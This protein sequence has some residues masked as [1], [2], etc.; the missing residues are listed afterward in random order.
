MDLQ[1]FERIEAS[2]RQF[3][4]HF[5]PAFARKQWRERSRDYLRGLLVQSAERSNAENLA[6]AVPGASPRVLQR[7]LTEARWDDDAVTRR[8]QQDLALRLT[9][10]DAVW[11]VDESGFPKQGKKSVG[12]A[13]QY[14]GALGKM[15]NCQVGVFLAY[16]S[17]R[18]RAL[19]DKRLFLPKEWTDDPD[20]CAAAGVPEAQRSYRTKTEIALALL[21]RAQRWGHLQAGWVTGDDAYGVVPEFRDALAQAGLRYVLE[22]PSHLT[23]WPLQPTWEQPV[24]G[25]FGRPP[26]ARPVAAQRQTVRERAVVLPQEAWQEITVAVGAQGP[27]TYRFACERVRVTRRRKPG[28]ELWLIQKQNLDGTEPRAF[29]SNAPGDT[30]VET[31]AR[32]AMS[33]WPIETEFEDEKSQVALDEYEVRGWAGW[34]HHVTMCLLASAFLLRLPQEWGEKD[35]PDHAAA[36]LPDRLRTVAAPALDERG[37]AGVAGGDPASQRTGETLARQTPSPTKGS[38]QVGPGSWQLR[39]TSSSQVPSLGC[40]DSSL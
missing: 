18:G 4:A 13:R 25:G 2:F 5:A 16:V 8:L 37:V 29:F 36:G 15:A 31:L 7:F 9:H 19:V 27:R 1:D 40:V 3:H 39:A 34:H 6:E 21:Q 23:V 26:K 28:E 33:R 22:V 24:Y 10:P 30:P 35:A 14:C 32:V 38:A 20:R 12:V 17:P 11:A